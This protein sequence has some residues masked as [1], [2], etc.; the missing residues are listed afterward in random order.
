MLLLSSTP[1]CSLISASDR[2]FHRILHAALTARILLN[3]R[4]T[5]YNNEIDTKAQLEGT[6]P[7]MVFEMEPVEAGESRGGIGPNE[8][9]GSVSD[10][11][12]PAQGHELSIVVS[13]P[14][15]V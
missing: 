13:G 15:L 6:I 1:Y 4:R 10:T 7:T 3:I 12:H 2:S 9:S 11:H 5:A 14:R 8:S